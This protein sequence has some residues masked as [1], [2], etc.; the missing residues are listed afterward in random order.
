[1]RAVGRGAM[2]LHRWRSEH[3]FVQFLYISPTPSVLFISSRITYLD[4]QRVG[5]DFRIQ[6]L[7]VGVGSNDTLLEGQNCLDDTS[8]TGAAFKMANIRLHRSSVISQIGE[9]K[10]VSRDSTGIADLEDFY[11][12]GKPVRW[13]RLQS[14]RRVASLMFGFVQSSRRLSLSPNRRKGVRL[15]SSVGLKVSRMV[16][17]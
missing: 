2:G 7:K 15:T 17:A 13:R 9:F 10:W 1:M 12:S 5:I 14:D 6:P 3:G 8:N 4:V 11:M 16:H